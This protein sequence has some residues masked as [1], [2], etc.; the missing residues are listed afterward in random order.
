MI[1]SKQASKQE[2]K[3]ASRQAIQSAGEQPS[4]HQDLA[5]KLASL[6]AS[7]P[8]SKPADLQVSKLAS[9]QGREQ[10]KKKETQQAWMIA[11]KQVSEKAS[12]QASKQASMQVNQQASEQASKQASKQ[13]EPARMLLFPRDN[14]KGTHSA[15]AHEEI[16][17]GG[18]TSDGRLFHKWQVRG[19][20]DLVLQ[21]VEENQASRWN[22][23]IRREV[24]SEN[25]GIAATSNGKLHF[26]NSTPNLGNTPHALFT[27]T[28]EHPQEKF[29]L[30]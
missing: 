9:Q 1:V 27:P 10:A 3:P 4:N 29:T 19:R 13:G 16:V 2:S 30:K 6:Q 11:S 18:N 25:R 5:R 22:L 24:R 23:F 17:L 21:I 26:Y 12:K 15:Q 28:P 14:S 7:E 8:E 20:N